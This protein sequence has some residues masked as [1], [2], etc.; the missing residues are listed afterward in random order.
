[1]QDQVIVEKEPNLC[2]KIWMIITTWIFGLAAI[3]WIS[4]EFKV[5]KINTIVESV[6]PGAGSC[7]SPNAPNWDLCTSYKFSYD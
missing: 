1:M 5:F 3:I 6:H 2:F 4:Y 7:W